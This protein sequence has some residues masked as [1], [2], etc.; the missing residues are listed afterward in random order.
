MNKENKKNLILCCLCLHNVAIFKDLQLQ[1]Q[2]TCVFDCLHSNN[3]ESSWCETYILML[4]RISELKPE[5]IMTVAENISARQQVTMGT[6]QTTKR[7]QQNCNDYDS[8]GTIKSSDT[9]K[10]NTCWYFSRF[11]FCLA[12]NKKKTTIEDSQPEQK[13]TDEALEPVT[14]GTSSSNACQAGASLEAETSLLHLQQTLHGHP[15]RTTTYHQPLA[16]LC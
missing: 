4:W 7:H 1:V 8:L 16:T 2:V 14:L 11:V 15:S 13:G 6:E 5:S 9:S 3:S 10:I 12:K